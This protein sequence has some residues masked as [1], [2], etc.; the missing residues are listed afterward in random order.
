[1]TIICT[2]RQ[3]FNVHPDLIK[4]GIQSINKQVSWDHSDITTT[5]KIIKLLENPLNPAFFI[6]IKN[7]TNE[8]F[9]GYVISEYR[10][11]S[12]YDEHELH[13]RYLAVNSEFSRQGLGTRL[14]QSVF[15]LAKSE[16]K[17][18]TLKHEKT[19]ELY[20]FYGNFNPVLEKSLSLDFND[21][22]QPRFNPERSLKAIQ[23]GYRSEAGSSNELAKLAL[24]TCVF[25]MGIFLAIK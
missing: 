18:V 20:Q 5:N 17:V 7:E 12:V 14:M 4:N 22:V 9:A 1:M 25:V 23:T 11:S 24:I 2:N 10:Y 13:V 15:E 21:F 3:D 8:T 19:I 6:F 16:N